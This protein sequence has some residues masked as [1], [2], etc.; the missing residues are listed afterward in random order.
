MTDLKKQMSV[1]LDVSDVEA[2]AARGK[3]SL[4]DFATTAV[5]TGKQAATGVAQAGKATDDAGRKVDQAAKKS[6]QATRS[7]QQSIERQIAL[8]EAGSKST[9]GYY[10]VLA[11]Q[12]GADASALKPY[13]D[14]LDAVVAKNKAAATAAEAAVPALQRQGVSAA[15]TAAAMRMVP[16]QFTDIVV[17]LQGGQ[18][19]LTVLLQ[20]GGQLKD[21][22]GGIGAAA[23]GIGGYVL[24][25]VSPLTVT[26]AAVAALTLAIYQ[27]SQENG[28]YVKSLILTGNSLGVTAS[29][30][31]EAAQRVS[32]VVGTQHEAAG[33]LAAIAE[34]GKIPR[35]VMEQ[36]G[37]AAV[38]M[39]RALGTEIGKAVE[40]F[41]K[42]ADEP[43]RAS[44]KLNEA[45]HY[46]TQATYERIRS[47]EEQGKKEEAAAVAI[48]SYAEVAV[49]RMQ[50]IERQGGVLSRMWNDI[51][52]DAKE[53][54]DMMMGLG[55]PK[56]AGEAL[57]D[58][59]QRVQDV[60]NPSYAPN[61]GV[62][63]SMRLA[64]GMGSTVQAEARTALAEQSRKALRDMD[65]AWAQGEKARDESA[66]IAATDRLAT[67]AKEIQSNADKRKKAIEQLQAD[68]KRLGEAGFL[69]VTG[70]KTLAEM[71]DA[72]NEKFKDPKDPKTKAYQD[73]AATKFLETQR[74]TEAALRGQ[75]AGES[76]LTEAAREQLKFQQL[77]ADLKDKKILTADQ[78]S[79][80]AAKDAIAKQLQ[81]NVELSNQVEFEKKIEEIVRKSKEEAIEFGRQM[82]AIN[83]SIAD[84]AKN[85][86]EQYDRTLSAFGLGNR[87]REEVAAQKEIYREFERYRLTA[88]KQAAEK[89]QL[90]S[91]AYAEELAKINQAQDQAL[92]S[93][94]D[95]Y[96]RL[97]EKQGD[98]TNGAREA[99]A[100]YA[101][102]A[103][104]VAES[105]RS[106]FERAFGGM[107]DALVSFAT[108]GKADF[109]SLANSI[110]ADLIRIQVRAAMA[111]IL[112]DG[113]GGGGIAG[114]LLGGAQAGFSQTSLGSSGFGSGL[115]YGNQDLGLY[116]AEGGFTGYGGKYEPAGIVHKGEYVINADSTAKVGLATL[117]RINRY[118]YAAGG[119]V[120][121]AG[122]VGASM[123]FNLI[124][125]SS[126]PMTSDNVSFDPRTRTVIVRDAVRAA[127]AEWLDPNSRM[128]K[129]FDRN[130][131]SP[132]NRS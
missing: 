7:L 26:A 83:L 115:A 69:K 10:E 74:Q 97:R 102:S 35:D 77:I 33:A 53:A 30:L 19:P 82:Q 96:A 103:K 81:L 36:V 107:E 101:D 65:A 56:T 129:N 17:G 127:A 109:R 25:L 22:F 41:T 118:G 114:L 1:G 4:Q 55:R 75:L 38:A 95:Y 119:L 85:R 88:T 9:G 40:T 132:K 91:D 59:R 86:G 31:Q 6:E 105:T 27:G 71:I 113:K 116:L 124:N 32:Q 58:A 14:Q 2:G 29:Q 52:R 67:L 13:L 28:A 108:T 43:T 45:Q 60:A 112:G 122:A 24:S 20:Q 5:N 23:R 78:Q 125:Q 34:S 39:N 57:A 70:G 62:W 104:N 50:A 21:M 44:E 120:G 98:W 3:K 49:G 117:E 121:S 51:A 84:S 128:R 131:R 99:F 64:L 16:A 46:L 90:G 100:N 72:A 68:Y 15:Q 106:S 63:D 61:A 37:A 47:L 80:L 76:K 66:K 123:P 93:Q 92:G 79:L 94:R 126:V 110:I 18:A 8:L 11:R 48:S 73:D 89:N 87:A 130:Y 42:L 12:R 111:N 54:W